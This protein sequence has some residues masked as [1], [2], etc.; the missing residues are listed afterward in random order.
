VRAGP[1]PHFIEVGLRLYRKYLV[2][3]KLRQAESE[4]LT[5]RSSHFQITPTI[6]VKGKQGSLHG[7]GNGRSGKSPGYMVPVVPVPV[8]Q[9]VT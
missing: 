3:P 8:R 9:R 4:D 7:T 6:I 1:D 5:G 2:R